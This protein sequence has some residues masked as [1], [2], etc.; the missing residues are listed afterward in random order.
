MDDKPIVMKFFLFVVVCLVP[1]MA[2]HANDL[3]FMSD[4]NGEYRFDT[5][6]LQGSL[7]SGGGSFGLSGLTHLPSGIRLD[8]AA[9]GIFSHYR[10]FT[11]NR[12]YGHAAWDWPSQATRLADGAVQVLWPAGDGRPFELKTVYRWRRPDTLDLE[13]SVKA[14]QDLPEFES[15]LASYFSK[16]FPASSVYAREGS[17]SETHPGFVSTEQAAGHWQ[18]FP[19]DRNAVQLIQDG[20]WHLAPNPVAWT[21]RP[22]M[23]LPIAIR[24]HAK[25]DLCAIL[26]APPEHCFAI[27][28]PFAGEGHFSVYLS[29]FGGSVSAG[30]TACARA[31]LVI[32]D[33]PTDA[34]ILSMYELYM[35]D[36]AK[37][38]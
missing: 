26:M 37:T 27:S 4:T 12:R 38:Q 21:I 2:T 36:L 32:A 20:R 6:I 9:Y 25:S 28:T 15:F 19:R 34:E 16:D 31:R 14:Q 30:E 11:R 13:T 24:R 23:A 33:A 7:R 3:G 29:L 10:V 8:G 1:V 5:G 17:S 35:K 18:M 22:D